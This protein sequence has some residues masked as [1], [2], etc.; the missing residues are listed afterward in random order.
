MMSFDL[1]LRTMMSFKRR[2]SKALNND[3][4]QVEAT[5]SFKHD[6]EAVGRGLV[7]GFTD[8]TL[9]FLLDMGLA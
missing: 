9:F 5:T 4:L 6:N 2:R 7:L 3:E 8:G 1:E